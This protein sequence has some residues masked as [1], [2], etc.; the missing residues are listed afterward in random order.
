MNVDSPLPTDL[1]TCQRELQHTRAAL[2][3]SAMIN[4]E[5]QEKIESLKAEL[6][7]FKRYVYGRRSERRVDSPGQGRLFEEPSDEDGQS[8][9]DGEPQEEE[10]KY[11]RRRRGHGW[12][13]LPEG[14][15][16]EEVPIDVPESERKCE[17]CGELKEQIGEDRTERVEFI[18]GRIVVKVIIRPKYACKKKHGGVQQAESPPSPVP[19]GRFDFG[20]VSEVIASKFADHLPLYRQQ[21]RL[22]RCGIEL[23]RSTLCEIVKHTAELLQPLWELERLRILA[24][25][26]LGADDTPIRLRAPA[27]PQGI[28]TARF[29]LYRGMQVAPYNVFHFYESRSRD[30]PV[31][32]L[33]DFNGWVKVDAY[34]VQDGVY[35]G[36]TDRI[37]ASC[38]WAHA[39]RKFDEAWSSHPKDCAYAVGMI[40]QLYDIED[41]ARELS[42]EERLQLRQLEAAPILNDLRAWLEDRSGVLPP[43]LK[44]AQAIQYSLNQWEE[45]SS[46]LKDGRLPIDNNDTEG[47]LRRMTI[48]RKNWLFIGSPEAGPRAATIYTVVASAARH[49]LDVWAY[50]RD[51]LERLAV[52]E[53]DVARLLPDAWA[54]THPE[55]I[56]TYRVREREARA[57]A[58]R[59]RRRRRRAAEQARPHAPA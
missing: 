25:G 1:E 43:K 5:R 47:E 45:L 27:H 17:C 18:P 56:R 7:L 9:N 23:S 16:R 50:L 57:V 32:F 39:R 24:A 34:G 20:F 29:W 59:D 31:E 10:I 19:G 49:H 55:A 37:W 52:G 46:Y 13:K 36:S 38:C 53:E 35:C 8:S 22:A 12:G 30:G 54:T 26:L 2:E 48:G 33:E 44:V 6:E 21:D 15:P 4:E 58:T 40:R 42:A 14:L 3:E 41:R 51:V 28:R 11:R